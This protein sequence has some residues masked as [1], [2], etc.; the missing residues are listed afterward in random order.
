MA[1]SAATW[2]RTLSR[3]IEPSG[4]RVVEIAAPKGANLDVTGMVDQRKDG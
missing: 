4:L 2:P 3:S 1:S